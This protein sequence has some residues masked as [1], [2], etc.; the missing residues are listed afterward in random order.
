MLHWNGSMIRL[1]MKLCTLSFCGKSG[2][3][4]R[5]PCWPE[6]IQ[7]TSASFIRCETVPGHQTDST[8]EA[9]TVG[10]STDEV[11]CRTGDARGGGGRMSGI[12]CHVS[13]V[14]CQV[15]EVSEVS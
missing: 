11:N 13:G 7:S 2:S 6:L 12:A 15:S 5:M 4:T 10:V 9:S 8:I 3:Q 1:D 14:R